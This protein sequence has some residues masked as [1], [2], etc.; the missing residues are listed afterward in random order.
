MKQHEALS[1]L[2]VL[3]A[4][5]QLKINVPFLDVCSRLDTTIAHEFPDQNSDW[6]DALWLAELRESAK[7]ENGGYDCTPLNSFAFAWTGTEGQHFSFLVQDSKVDGNSPVIL[8]APDNYWAE[9]VIVAKNFRTFMR[10]ALRYG[11]FELT[12]L[13]YAPQEAIQAF[14]VDAKPIVVEKDDCYEAKERIRTYAANYLELSPFYYTAASFENLQ[15]QYKP[16]LKMSP[17]YV[18]A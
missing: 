14:T 5:S 8:T 11:C 9:N 15:Q 13:A 7:L 6:L 4:M 10:L 2:S 3:I 1:S 12:E 17:E 18:E 16:L